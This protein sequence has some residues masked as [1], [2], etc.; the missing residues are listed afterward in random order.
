M[1]YEFYLYFSYGCLS[2]SICQ[3]VSKNKGGGSPKFFNSF[4]VENSFVNGGFPHV[5]NLLG[6]EKKG[7]CIAENAI[8]AHSTKIFFKGPIIHFVIAYVRIN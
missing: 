7:V 3:F 1:L 8:F 2:I 5:Q 6:P 4:F